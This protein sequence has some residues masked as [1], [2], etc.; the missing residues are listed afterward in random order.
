MKTLGIILIVVGGL[1]MA[2]TGFNFVTEEKVVDLGPLEVNKEKNHP[3]QW[4]PIIGGILFVGGIVA[5]VTAK[6]K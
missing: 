4:S 3:V 1:M 2:I 5:L 6:K